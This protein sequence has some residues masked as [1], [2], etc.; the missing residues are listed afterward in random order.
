MASLY[1][2][3]VA[4]AAIVTIGNELLSGDVANTNGSWLA[5]RLEAVGVQV[6]LLAVLPDEIDTV[7]AFLRAHGPTVD[8]V[9]VTGG[10]GGTPDDVTREA[11]AATFGIEQVEFPAVAEVLRARFTRDPDYVTPWARLPEGSR[12]LENPLGGAPGFQVGNAYV[13]PGLPS[14]MEAM[15]ELV[16]AELAGAAPIASWRR[17]YATTESRI[18][19]VLVELEE[20]HPSVRVG[21]YPTFGP[22]GSTVEVVLKSADAGE[23][24]AA[25][26]WAETAL[27][28]ATR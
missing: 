7:A 5:G 2:P 27:A 17:R 4:T 18:V 23:L 1:S 13:L 11:M 16:E 28:D 22:D 20:R 10:L 21:S 9:I 25:S 24:A 6:R 15:Y 3:D 19:R 8:I 12:P 26:A 14:E